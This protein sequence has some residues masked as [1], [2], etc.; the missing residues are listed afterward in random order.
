MDKQRGKTLEKKKPIPCRCYECPNYKTCMAMAKRIQPY[1]TKNLA[2][3]FA[4]APPIALFL[5]FIGGVIF[6]K[7]RKDLWRLLK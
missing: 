6:E 2:E 7:I 1:L 4:D 5:A 3:Q